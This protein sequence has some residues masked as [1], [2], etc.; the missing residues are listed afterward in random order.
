MLTY[1]P[2]SP[3][4]PDTDDVSPSL[5]HQIERQKLYDVLDFAEKSGVQLVSTTDSDLSIQTVLDNFD[6]E[7]HLAGLLSTSVTV[8]YNGHQRTAFPTQDEPERSL[9]LVCADALLQ[10]SN[11][12]TRSHI[13]SLLQP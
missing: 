6:N 10:S 8:V 5:V 3:D 7:F 13:R 1:S 11:N 4:D 9:A 2:F 12:K